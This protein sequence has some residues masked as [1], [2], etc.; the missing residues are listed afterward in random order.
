MK[1]LLSLIG[2]ALI[3]SYLQGCA[4]GA[5][6]A[7][8]TSVKTFSAAKNHMPAKIMVA[9]VE[10]G[11]S[12]NPL[13]TSQVDSKSFEEALTA[14]LQSNGLLAAGSGAYILKPTLLKLDQPIFGLD[15]TVKAN[16]RYVLKDSASE[17]ELFNETINSSY[18]ATFN[19][20][21]AAIKRL[22]LANEGAIRKNIEALIE[23]LAKV[24]L[25]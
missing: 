3:A 20:A 21:F 13:W 14:S 4:S 18:T 9:P 7:G 5:T 12:T 6:V 25:Q 2:I 11:K 24:P 17:K 15:L 23:R 22:R 16:V 10:G 19:D 1:K 8:M